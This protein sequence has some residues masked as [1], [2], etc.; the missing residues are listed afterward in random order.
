MKTSNVCAPTTA[1]N[2]TIY[3]ALE[4][5]RRTWLV[6]MYSP[7]RDR[8]SQYKVDGGDHA[9]LLKLIAKIRARAAQ[10]LGFEPAVVSCYEAGY[11]G[12]WL[13]RLLTAA[14][15]TNYV[16]DPASIAVEQR[17]RRAKSDRIDGKQLLRTL[18][19]HCAGEPRVVR[20][21]RVPSPEQEDVRRDTREQERLKTEEG[22]HS[23][24]IK[25]LVRVVGVAAGD[26]RRH[27]YLSWLAKQRDWQKNPVPPRLLAE[28][29]REHARLRLVIE[30]LAALEEQVSPG[31][32]SPAAVEM[33][34]RRDFLFQLKSLGPAFS[35]RL[36]NEAFYKNFRNRREVGAYFGLDGTPWR[37]GDTNREQGISKAGNRR[38]RHAAIELA[39]L[40]L[41]HQPDSALSK[42][43][44][45][46]AANASKRIRRITIVALARK[47]MVAL[48]R[49]LTT[50]LI[51]E[52]AVFKKA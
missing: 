13:H 9:G 24:R 43:F 37:S 29:K 31:P 5:S 39:W 23:N 50:G 16:F 15:I 49:F 26:P 38:A 42:W 25:A 36:V 3:L 2:G 17:G 19:Q 40:W 10:K 34:R 27:D 18:R 48:W 52:G 12:F 14:G 51:P 32:L 46:R 7:D 4:L 30:Q 6:T 11:D 33:G 28:I 1:N 41:R 45:Q 35:S 22:S 8:I 47:L 44:R 20:I 21:V